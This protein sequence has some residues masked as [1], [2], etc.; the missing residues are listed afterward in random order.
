M[1]ATTEASEIPKIHVT[2]RNW[3]LWYTAKTRA[4]VGVSKHASPPKVA[5]RPQQDVTL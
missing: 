3:H 5:L 2:T 1:A 4:N